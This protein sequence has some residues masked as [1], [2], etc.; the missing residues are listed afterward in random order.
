MKQVMSSKHKKIRRGHG[1]NLTSTCGE[2]NKY[3]RPN[4][5]RAD[6]RRQRLSVEQSFSERT[7]A[8]WLKWNH[9]MKNEKSMVLVVSSK[10]ANEVSTLSRSVDRVHEVQ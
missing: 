4:S 2:K 6:S 8:V 7:W 10:V 3:D 1:R 5:N 9:E